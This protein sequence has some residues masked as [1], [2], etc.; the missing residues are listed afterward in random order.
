MYDTD[1]ITTVVQVAILIFSAN[2]K[3]LA[4]RNLHA[5]SFNISVLIIVLAKKTPTTY[6]QQ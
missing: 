6:K 2:Y 1:C 3:I 4:Y 5:I